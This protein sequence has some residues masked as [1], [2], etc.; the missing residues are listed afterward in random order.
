[1]SGIRKVGRESRRRLF[2][3][4][5]SRDRLDEAFALARE[6]LE[7]RER[8]LPPNSPGIA[9]ALHNFGVCLARR[10]KPE[11]AAPLYQRAIAIYTEAYGPVDLAVADTASELAD[12]LADAGS[13]C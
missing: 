2:N 8:C 10:G 12:V 6:V 5:F 11:E 3:I 7:V 4:Q 13:S 9:N 1:V